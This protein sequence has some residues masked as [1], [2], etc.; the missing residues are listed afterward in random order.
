M[1][2]VQR[3]RPGETREKLMTAALTL[4][5]KGRHFAS[6]GIREVTRQ[7]GVV[8]T[9]FY[10]HFR[11]VDD[12]GL[13][14]VDELGLVLRRMMREARENVLQADKLIEESVGIFVAHALANRNF[15]MFMAQGLAGE[16]R[17]V[18]EGIRSEMRFFASELANDLRRLKLLPHLSDSDLDMTCELVVRTVAFSLTDILSI[19]PEDDYQI[20]LVR[21]RTTRF[22]QLILIGAGH[23]ESS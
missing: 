13:Q 21:K 8:P 11:S 14:L 16:S 9:S 2:D 1:A 6:I 3:R 15:F 10:R 4:V 20:E 7:A 19:S 23:W 5:G 12:L 17:A 18:Q 22:L